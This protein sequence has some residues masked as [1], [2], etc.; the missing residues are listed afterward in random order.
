MAE[1]P[2]VE[3]HE[4]SEVERNMKVLRTYSTEVVA[5]MSGGKVRCKA[6][7]L[8][9]PVSDGAK[10]VHFIRHGEGYHN[11]AQ[12]EWRNDPSWDGKSEPYTKDN[13]PN[14]RYVDAELNDKGRG[15]AVALQ[16]QTEPM[17]KPELMVVS[18]MRRAT[19]T[20]LLAFE[21][22]VARGELPCVA[23]ELLHER[24]GRHTCDK[25][26]SKTQLAALFP[27]V[28]YDLVF[29]DE[30]PYWGDGWT[31]EP[32]KDTALRGAKFIE[33]LLARPEKHIT[34]AAHSAILLALFNAV[35]ECEEE[36]TSTWFGTG[37]MRSV[38]LSRTGS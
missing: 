28:T 11:V 13:D 2:A 3:A 27:Q 29:D 7:Q 19:L 38:L 18:P 10:L 34:V 14:W 31:R 37:E 25:R 21:P 17:L 30:D 22:H 24:A 35:F 15:Q 32:W 12:R 5:T 4:A 23:H 33:W 16:K 26:L 8:D 36:A 9:A 6:A 20:G 1:Q